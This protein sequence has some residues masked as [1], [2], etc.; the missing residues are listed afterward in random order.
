MKTKRQSQRKMYRTH[1][2][3]VVYK[4]NENDYSQKEKHT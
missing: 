3:N 1:C 2:Y 4:Q